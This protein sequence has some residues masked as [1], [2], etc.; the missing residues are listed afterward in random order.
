MSQEHIAKLDAAECRDASLSV[1]ASAAVRGAKPA[2]LFE[3]AL[4]RSEPLTSR[5]AREDIRSG[6]KASAA[7]RQALLLL[8]RR[9]LHRHQPVELRAH[10]RELT[11]NSN[12]QC[13]GA[14]FFLLGKQAR[15]VQR[16]GQFPPFAPSMRTL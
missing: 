10:R 9:G 2:L 3:A 7:G 15:G 1:L 13:A 6:S 16:A 4:L 12:L 11:L 5:L 14:R 8:K